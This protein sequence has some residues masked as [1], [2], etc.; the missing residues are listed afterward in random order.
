MQKLVLVM[1]ANASGKTYFIRQ[2]FSKEDRICFNAFDYQQKAY[3]QYGGHIPR[4]MVF[5]C[6]WEAEQ[7]L[8]K[9]VVK[10]LIS[11][12]DVVVEQ[13]FFKAKRRINFVDEVR[14]NTRNTEITLYY[15]YPD[16]EEWTVYIHKRELSKE[17]VMNAAKSIEYPNIAEGFDAVYE[18]RSG[19][20]VMISD[21]PKQE[22]LVP[23]RK[24]IADEKKRLERERLE[25]EEKQ[26]FL[27]SFNE[28]PFWH[29]C[30][31]CGKKEWLTAQEAFEAGWDYPPRMGKFG[32]LSPRTCGDCSIEGTL[33]WKS[34]TENERFP[35]GI[36]INEQ[37]TEEEGN[38]WDRIRREPYSLLEK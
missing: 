29:I 15:M 20:A 11:G 8:L 12:K 5:S 22:I 34:Q 16:D 14:K 26:R 4:E 38:L 23:A 2:N 7:N 17:A 28:R 1:G 31:C 24:E 35:F 9:D 10:E 25:R 33:F 3:E 30:E 6:L 18:V 27:E 37:L 19:Q 36:V 21:P 32:L 13:T